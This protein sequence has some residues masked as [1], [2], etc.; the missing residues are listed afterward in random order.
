MEETLLP[1][2]DTPR[3]QVCC[4]LTFGI[5]ALLN[6]ILMI[7]IV[8]TIISIVPDIQLTMQDTQQVVPEI[9]TTVQD[10]RMMLPQSQQIL[11]DLK[12]MMPEIR[13]G[14]RILDQLCDASGMC[15]PP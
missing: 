5:A 14:L 13:N 3:R 12:D 9:R 10:V 15:T 8:S 2:E 1:S 6:L 4:Y 7:V 11:N